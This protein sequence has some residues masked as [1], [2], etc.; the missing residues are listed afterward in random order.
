MI[1]YVVTN[2]SVVD[3]VEKTN[4]IGIYKTEEQ[5]TEQYEKHVNSGLYNIFPMV[6]GQTVLNVEV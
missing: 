4:I 2:K 5:A 3:G 1:V 6:V